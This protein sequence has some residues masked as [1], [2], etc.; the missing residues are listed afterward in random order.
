MARTSDPNQI[1]HWKNLLESQVQSG[2]SVKQFCNANNIQPYTF[3]FWRRKFTPKE[4]SVESSTTPSG[5][6]PVRVVHPSSIQTLCI[7]F[8]CGA[9][10][11]APSETIRQAIEQ[12]LQSEALQ[13]TC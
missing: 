4:P 11:E 2:L 7:R 9:S 10:I 12:I 1:Q 5:L 13:R 3:Y 6:V 8:A